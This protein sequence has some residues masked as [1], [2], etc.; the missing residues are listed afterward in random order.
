MSLDIYVQRP[1]CEHCGRNGETLAEAGITSNVS[2]VYYR[3]MRAAGVRDGFRGLDGRTIGE[4]TPRLEMA[5]EFYDRYEQ[6]LRK[7]WEGSDRYNGWG[8][9][10]CVR[11]VL[12]MLLKQREHPDAVI[13]VL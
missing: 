3:V 4:V 7:H 8:K 12:M 11:R 5:L 6:R 10:A 1:S 13:S 2:P 9:T